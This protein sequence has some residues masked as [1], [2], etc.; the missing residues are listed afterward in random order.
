MNFSLPS[1]F[2]LRSMN[3][4]YEYCLKERGFVILK[5]EIQFPIW[6]NSKQITSSQ[7]MN[8]SEAI[9]ITETGKLN[10]SYID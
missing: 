8:Q 4:L 10:N 1:E 9:F 7:V 3:L 6:G 2:I 5:R